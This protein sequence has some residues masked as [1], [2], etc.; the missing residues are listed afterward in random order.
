LLVLLLSKGCL[1]FGLFPKEQRMLIMLLRSGIEF[2][3]LV[4]M[5]KESIFKTKRGREWRGCITA[6][7]KPGNEVEF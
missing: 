1:E 2:L 3:L 5:E 4:N 7:S 6:K